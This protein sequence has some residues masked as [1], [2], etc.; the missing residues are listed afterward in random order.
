MAENDRKNTAS[1]LGEESVD[2]ILA[3][4]LNAD[5]T[6]NDSFNGLF[7]KYTVGTSTNSSVPQVDLSDRSDEQV[8]GGK[9]TYDSGE[10]TY[11][12]ERNTD[13][14]IED[15]M[16]DSVRSA[17]S[18]A[19][20]EAQRPEF[21]S[22][23]DVR[24][25]TMGVGASEQRVVFD[26]D[27]EETAKKEAARLERVR[28][29]RLLRGDSAYARTFVAGGMYMPQ[30]SQYVNAPGANPLYIDP[31]SRD[32]DFEQADKNSQ[33]YSS[34]KKSFFPEG[35]SVVQKSNGT[36]SGKTERRNSGNG[37]SASKR[38]ADVSWLQ[39]ED[40]SDK[41]KKKKRFGKKKQSDSVT[42]ASVLNGTDADNTPEQDEE[43]NNT[44][45]E[46]SYAVTQT[47]EAYELEEIADETE[48]LRSTVAEIVDKYNKRNEEDARRRREEQLREEDRRRE[49]ELKE[50]RKEEELRQLKKEINPEIVSAMESEEEDSFVEYEDFSTEKASQSEEAEKSK[51]TR[52]YGVVFDPEAISGGEYLEKMCESISPT[53][54]EGT[55]DGENEATEKGEEKVNSNADSGKTK[56]KSG[57][58]SRRKDN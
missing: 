58:F 2:D 26:A 36:A 22:T 29:D 15:K 21:T 7:A 38:N 33:Y 39:V 55:A 4:I 11:S 18:E 1:D 25:P 23:G 45:N 5:G 30:K 17:Y 40:K 28:Q 10:Y 56:G 53:S 35:F 27:W 34:Q 42:E 24:Y 13:E 8:P 37:N 19:S 32:D 48:G 31:L 46:N 51:D 14:R 54:G 9:V 16:P 57:F 41:K 47:Y 44:E 12:R 20:S 50:R 49:E 52:T 43:V 3:E 6:F